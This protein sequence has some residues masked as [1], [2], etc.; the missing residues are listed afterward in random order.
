MED[1]TI[2]HQRKS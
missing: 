1:I 2:I